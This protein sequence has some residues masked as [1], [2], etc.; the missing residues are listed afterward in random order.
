MLNHLYSLSPTKT[1][2][3]NTQIM[4]Q[5]V[6]KPQTNTTKVRFSMRVKPNPSIFVQNPLKAT[7][8]PC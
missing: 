7:L 6:K 3:N 5:K 1:H 8:R 2:L 4:Q